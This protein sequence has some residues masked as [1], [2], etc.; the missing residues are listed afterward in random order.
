MSLGIQR[1]CSHLFIH[2]FKNAVFLFAERFIFDYT[3]FFCFKQRLV[4]KLHHKDK[5]LQI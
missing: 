1:I 4:I 5:A 3:Q 2:L